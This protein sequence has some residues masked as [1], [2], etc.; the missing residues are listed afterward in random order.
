MFL[1][2]ANNRF[3][4]DGLFILD[5]P[6]AALSPSRQLSFLKIIDLHV[7]ELGGQFI[8][9][10]HSPIIMAYPDA[11]IFHLKADGIAPIEYEETEH[12]QVTSGFLSNRRSYFKHLFAKSGD[13]DPAS[14]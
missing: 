11:T 10:T 5:E 6:E 4:R 9:A 1:A 2:L 3:G 12:F 8:I 13:S 14:R 7:R